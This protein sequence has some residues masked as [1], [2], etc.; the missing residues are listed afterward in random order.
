MP[1]REWDRS[2][3][4]DPD[5]LKRAQEKLRTAAPLTVGQRVTPAD[6]DGTTRDLLVTTPQTADGEVSV[7]ADTS[8]VERHETLPN[9]ILNSHHWYWSRTA[10]GIY[11]AACLKHLG[12]DALKPKRCGER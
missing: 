4:V 6:L 1:S 7:V 11:C 3:A 9:A 12:D 8:A 2:T 5:V 10:H